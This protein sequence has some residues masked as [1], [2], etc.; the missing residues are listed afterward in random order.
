EVQDQALAKALFLF[1]EGN[2]RE[3]QA[4]LS[5]GVEAQP[6]ADDLRS[7]ILRA[8]TEGEGRPPEELELELSAL[9]R[10]VQSGNGA[11]QRIERDIEALLREPELT[12][13]Q[14]RRLQALRQSLSAEP[15]ARTLAELYPDARVTSQ[16]P[17]LAGRRDVSVRWRF[18]R[19]PDSWSL[20]A[21]EAEP[22]RLRHFQSAPSPS[23]GPE[24]WNS[25]LRLPLLDPLDL[26]RPLTIAVEFRVAE[27]QEHS[28]LLF[29]VGGYHLLLDRGPAGARFG[30]TAGS[31]T[32]LL[33]GLAEPGAGTLEPFDGFEAGRTHVLEFEVTTLATNRRGRIKAIR[34]NGQEL[35]SS[36]LLSRPATAPV[37]SL[38]A[39]GDLDLY[40]VEL[41]GSELLLR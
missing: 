3:A 40:R 37:L 1:H 28:S 29:E 41:V 16:G 32:P 19:N 7:R 23:G 6:L 4:A 8:L 36:V 18:D 12:A 39:Q 11:R 5:Q 17:D 22:G 2:L 15:A 27:G 13:E 20:G 21:F 25:P 35:K 33:E 31:A 34:L 26:S 9:A 24:W 14:R 30:L 10:D 38:A